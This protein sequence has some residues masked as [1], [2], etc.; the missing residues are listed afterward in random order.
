MRAAQGMLSFLLPPIPCGLYKK[1]SRLPSA[2]MGPTR[3][4]R[5]I[6]TKSA[7]MLPDMRK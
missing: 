5:R 1:N 6:R 3:K 7:L 4:C 2:E